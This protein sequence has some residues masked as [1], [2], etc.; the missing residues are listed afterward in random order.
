MRH[1]I[2]SIMNATLLILIF[3]IVQ[4]K[5][6]HAYLD[7]A[8]GSYVIQVI[9]AFMLGGLFAI[10]T[11]WRSINNFFTDLFLKRKKDKRDND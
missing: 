1:L 3:L 2:D 5:E 8:S 9:I 6:A 7:P 11:F 4:P 10:K